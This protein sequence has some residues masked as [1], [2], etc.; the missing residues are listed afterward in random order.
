MVLKNIT[1]AIETSSMILPR[2]SNFSP[3]GGSNFPRPQLSSNS[4]LPENL[5][6]EIESFRK[7]NA[8]VEIEIPI[9]NAFT[10]VQCCP[11]CIKAHAIKKANDLGLGQQ[12]LNVIEKEFSGEIGHKGYY[13][14]GE[15]LIKL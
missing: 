2:S 11:Q 10:V 1:P 12:A 7:R 6:S 14:D 9:R 5:I 15:D 13:L 4:E 8:L 3:T